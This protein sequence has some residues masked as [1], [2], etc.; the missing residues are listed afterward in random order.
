VSILDMPGLIAF[1]SH[2]RDDVVLALRTRAR[3]LQSHAP[4]PGAVGS[5]DSKRHLAVI[6]HAQELQTLAT[7]IAREGR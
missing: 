6:A 3:H 5:E 2:Y 7:N 4:M 1:P